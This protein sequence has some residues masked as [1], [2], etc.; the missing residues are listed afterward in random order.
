MVVT[1]SLSLFS[2][3]S[4]VFLFLLADLTYVEYNVQT[5]IQ[6]IPVTIVTII[7]ICDY[8]DN[9]DSPQSTYCGVFFLAFHNQIL[10][11]PTPN[12]LVNITYIQMFSGLDFKV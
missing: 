7:S 10:N 11:R 3:K 1:Q 2:L 9:D 12:P 5:L 8:L 6:S 4:L